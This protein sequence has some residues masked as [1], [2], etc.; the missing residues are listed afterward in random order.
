VHVYEAGDTIVEGAS[1]VHEGMNLSDDEVV[2]LVTYV[3]AEGKPLAETE[4]ANCDPIDPV[5]E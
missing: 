5:I 4:L 2:L 1:Y 3:T